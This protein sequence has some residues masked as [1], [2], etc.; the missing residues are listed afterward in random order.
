MLS[1]WLLP[2]A[3]AI[4]A[5]ALPA[6]ALAI[7]NGTEAAQGEFPA[8]GALRID[9]DGNDPDP[10]PYEKFCGDSKRYAGQIFQALQADDLKRR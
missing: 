10:T 1:R 4:I 2:L 6:P 3:T 7:V 9:T 5:L 8:Q